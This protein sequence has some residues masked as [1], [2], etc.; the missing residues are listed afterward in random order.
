M[1]RMVYG[2]STRQGE[3]P[4]TQHRL[5]QIAVN[6]ENAEILLMQIARE[7][8]QWGR[9]DVTC[10]ESE[11]ARL[12]VRIGDVVRQSRNVVRDVV[13]ACGAHAH[14]LDNPLQRMLRDVHTLSC[15]T[16]FDLD[17][18]AEQYGRTLLD[19][20]VTMPV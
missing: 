20:P 7:T 1:E 17:I 4:V 8:E 9:S 14:F 11:R 5:G 18:S 15:H 10:P 12:R 2:T 3:K 16:V 13:E 6:A 19:L